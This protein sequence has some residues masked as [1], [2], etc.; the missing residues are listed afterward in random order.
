MYHFHYNIFFQ[1]AP[2]LSKQYNLQQVRVEN[3]SA[4]AGG[5]ALMRAEPADFKC[6]DSCVPQKT[7]DPSQCICIGMLRHSPK[8]LQTL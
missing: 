7:S 2:I 8:S 6:I 4:H 3:S 5:I 1:N